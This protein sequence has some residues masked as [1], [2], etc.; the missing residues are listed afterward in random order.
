MSTH[1][2]GECRCRTTGRLPSPAPEALSICGG[3]RGCAQPYC[4][5]TR[6][7]VPDKCTNPGRHQAMKVLIIHNSYQQPGGEDVAADRET[8]LLRQ[9]GH[10]VIEYR[11]SNHELNA[12]SLWGKLTLPKRVIWA[13]DAMQD[14]RALIHR[15]KP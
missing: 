13:G 1:R 12:L 7:A 14:I 5:S 6:G 4:S 15:E 2:G 8:S 3:V 10:E 9:A 11:R